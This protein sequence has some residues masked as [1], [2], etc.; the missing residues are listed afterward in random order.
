MC[1]C[2][3]ENKKKLEKLVGAEEG[4]VSCNSLEI[5]SG[6]TFSEYAYR[7]PGEKKIRNVPVLHSFCPTCGQ[8]YVSA[9]AGEE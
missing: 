4:S 7:K 9:E 5:L 6:R 3:E 2:V 8:P 1:S